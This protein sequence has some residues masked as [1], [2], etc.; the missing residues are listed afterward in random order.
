MTPPIVKL[1]LTT[2]LKVLGGLAAI[3]VG[4]SRK[5]PALSPH[6]SRRATQPLAPCTGGA[7]RT[8]LFRHA[9][10]AASASRAAIAFR[11][12]GTARSA[13]PTRSGQS[14]RFAGHGF[15]CRLRMQVSPLSRSGARLTVSL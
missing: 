15:L 1:C 4:R 8:G 12:V 2:G 11:E 14:L 13:R 5:A 9:G 6:R 3:A 7:Y 10:D